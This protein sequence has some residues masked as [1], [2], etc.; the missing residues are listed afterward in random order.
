MA[1]YCRGRRS[2][3]V[4]AMAGVDFHAD[5]S[6]GGA[7]DLDA[8]QNVLMVREKT[9]PAVLDALKKRQV[10]CAAQGNPAAVPQRIYR[11]RPAGRTWGG[12]RRIAATG[13]ATGGGRPAVG[14]RGRAGGR[15]CG[16]HSKR[17]RDRNPLG[18]DPPGLQVPRCQ[19]AARQILLPR[20]RQ[21]PT[22][23][24]AAF[25]PHFHCAAVSVPRAGQTAG[26]RSDTLGRAPAYRC[27]P[28]PGHHLPGPEKLF[29]VPKWLPQTGQ[30]CY[31]TK[32]GWTQKIR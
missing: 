23:R 11:H 20:R 30:L 24:K 31:G 7:V 12:F 3:P 1:D 22:G 17:Q 14:K 15:R 2:A 27:V 18:P 25:Q 19:T 9:G 10:L 13:G 29:P 26:H 21:K 4:W 32:P 28:H 8:F 16:D 6:R 5:R